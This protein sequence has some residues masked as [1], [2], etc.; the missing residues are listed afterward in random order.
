L[1]DATVPWRALLILA[2]PIAFELGQ[3]ATCPPDQ[4]LGIPD[5]P[6]LYFLPNPGVV[7][8]D[9][10]YRVQEALYTRGFDPGPIDGKSGAKTRE[11]M[12]TF[13]VRTGGT[14]KNAITPQL[15]IDLQRRP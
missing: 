14:G 7:R 11:A 8:Q 2:A 1:S 4:A 15:L 6:P 10:V 12:Q 3:F 5:Y 9:L 13:D